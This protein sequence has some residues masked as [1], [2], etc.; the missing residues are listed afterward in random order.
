MLSKEDFFK[1]KW[2]I[3]K[4]EIK[5]PDTTGSFSFQRA[6]SDAIIDI[7]TRVSGLHLGL[8][9]SRAE[10]ILKWINSF[11]IDLLSIDRWIIKNNPE[12]LPNIGIRWAEYEKTAMADTVHCV[13][14]FLQKNKERK[15]I[16]F[17]G[18]FWYFA[19]II[20]DQIN[21]IDQIKKDSL[22]VISYPFMKNLKVKNNMNQILQRCCE[23]NVPV[24]LDCIWLPLTKELYFLEHTDC[25]EMITHSMTKTLPLAGIKGGFCFYK[26]PL[27]IEMRHNEIHGKLG[28]FIFDKFIT[29]KGYW[30]VRDSHYELQKKWCGILGLEQHD[31]VLV[32][33]YENSHTL[34]EFGLKQYNPGNLFSLVPFF[35]HDS[36]CTKFLLEKK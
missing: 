32:G 6:K 15:P 34:G 29:E 14:E 1:L 25:I 16:I 3:A 4:N 19:K 30:Y 21:T 13:Y 10:H 7:H 5:F 23:L 26:K 18:E 9:A 36:V 22:L 33:K 8:T 11:K 27:P 35:N 28:A 31:L 17:D 2:L 12:Q 24:L 20:P